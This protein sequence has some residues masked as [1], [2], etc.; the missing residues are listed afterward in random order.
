MGMGMEMEIGGNGNS[1]CLDLIKVI[2]QR[3][4]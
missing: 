4:K 2:N 1:N 3:E